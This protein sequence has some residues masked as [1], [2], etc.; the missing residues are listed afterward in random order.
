MI[1]NKEFGRIQGE[2]PIAY[3]KML[4]SHLPGGTEENRTKPHT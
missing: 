2:I 3:L 1:M 4:L